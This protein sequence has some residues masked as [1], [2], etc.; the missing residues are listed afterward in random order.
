[1]YKSLQYSLSH[2]KLK[3]D[4][5]AK[6]PKAKNSIHF[7]QTQINTINIKLDRNRLT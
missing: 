4:K 3:T 7:Q 2:T 5:F 1:M 6:K